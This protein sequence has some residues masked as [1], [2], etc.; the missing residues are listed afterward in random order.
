MAKHTLKILCDVNTAKFLKYVFSTYFKKL[1]YFH[2]EKFIN[3][4]LKAL[5]IQKT[6]N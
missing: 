4:L 1:K 5:N 6:M 2:Y 3:W